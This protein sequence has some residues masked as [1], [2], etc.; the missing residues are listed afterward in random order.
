MATIRP[1]AGEVLHGSGH[2]HEDDQQHLSPE[3][4]AEAHGRWVAR[5]DLQGVAANQQRPQLKEDVH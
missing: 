3:S 1:K 4:A 2:D 5:S